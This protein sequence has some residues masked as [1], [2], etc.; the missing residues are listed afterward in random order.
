MIGSDFGQLQSFR[1][2]VAGQSA[3]NY[4]NALAA[5]RANRQIADSEDQ[6]D[7]HGALLEAQLRN[8]A[9]KEAAD[10]AYRFDRAQQNDAFTKRQL[11]L[12]SDAA[13]DSMVN[14]ADNKDFAWSQ[15]FH[16]D[17]WH[18]GAEAKADKRVADQL[19]G[20]LYGEIS[21]GNVTDQGSLAAMAQGR[22][23]KEQM[24]ALGSHLGNTQARRGMMFENGAKATADELTNEFRS[25]SAYPLDKKLTNDWRKDYMDSTGFAPETDPN[26][27]AETASGFIGANK[28]W[29]PGSLTKQVADAITARNEAFTKFAGS[30]LKDKA[31]AAS[32]IGDVRK[33]YFKTRMPSP[34]EFDAADQA[35]APEAKAYFNRVRGTAPAPVVQAGGKV[36]VISPSGQTGR[37]PAEDLPSAL[38][39]G[40][41]LVQ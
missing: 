8:A 4:F 38:Q 34:E 23:S 9:E 41:K 24:D 2:Q 27:D 31:N 29:F 3:A 35:T 11:D 40:Y 14:A 6:S 15:L 33:S 17:Q 39:K 28:F 1:N 10:R 7:M 37:I 25:S 30:K 20:Q 13:F 26:L 5:S 12:Q 19:F 36:V 16:Q 32:I 21:K 18:N 22:L